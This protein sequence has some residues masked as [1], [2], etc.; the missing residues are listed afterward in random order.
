MFL[1]GIVFLRGMGWGGGAGRGGRGLISNIS[2]IKYILYI[3]NKWGEIYVPGPRPA[4]TPPMVWS[5]PARPGK[6]EEILQIPYNSKWSDNGGASSGALGKVNSPVADKAT[7]WG[8]MESVWV[9]M[10]TI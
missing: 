9:H 3:L 7:I 4:W 2:S 6:Y 10:R 5:H 1:R 8:H